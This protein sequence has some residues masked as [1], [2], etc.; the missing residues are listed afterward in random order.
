MPGFTAAGALL[1]RSLAAAAAVLVALLALR[2]VSSLLLVTGRALPGAVG[3]ACRRGGALV[4][5]G[6]ARRMLALAVGLGAASA[7]APPASAHPVPAA[8]LA[9]PSAV[10][11][12]ARTAPTPSTARPHGLVVHRR[13]RDDARE[14]VVRRGDSLWS[15]ARRHLRA[16]A[17]DAEVA[18]AWPRWYAANR[19][20]I[21]PDPNLIL[22]GMRL[23]VPGRGPA[24]GP[25]PRPAGTPAQHHRPASHLDAS[26]LDPDRR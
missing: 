22:P 9:G 25:A 2:V 11:R 6:A 8:A 13:T 16:G 19:A 7:A 14:V 12:P 23:R 15:I 24:S 20:V 17:T 4:R 26:S 5:P 21:G 18:R 3:R 1:D 10:T